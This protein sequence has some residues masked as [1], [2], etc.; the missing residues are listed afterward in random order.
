MAIAPALIGLDWGTSNLRAYLI[1]DNGAILD[2]LEA[3]SG[4]MNWG[5]RG[6]AAAME[7]LVGC[8]LDAHASLP[9]IAAGMIGS[10]QGWREAPYVDCPA[11]AAGLAARMVSVEFRGN[12]RLHIVPG[13]KCH[14]DDGVPDVMRGEETQ[15]VGGMTCEAADQQWIV[16]PGT[17]SKWVEVGD[18]RIQRFASFMTGELYDILGKHSILCRLMEGEG[19]DGQAFESGVRRATTAGGLLRQIFSART[20]PLLNELLNASVASYLSGLLIGAEIEGASQWL[21]ISGGTEARVTVLAGPM[22]ASRY[23]CALTIKGITASVGPTDAAALGLL[24]IG[25]IGHLL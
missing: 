21:G 16:L 10:R 19:F 2:R 3:P 23:V 17:H 11:D 4:V 20:L 7:S 1:G 15:V 18:G 14:G 13:L 8:W 9:V 24:R 25:R 22:L 12:R 6:P 5:D